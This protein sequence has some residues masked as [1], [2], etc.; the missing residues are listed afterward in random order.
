MNELTPFSEADWARIARDWTSWWNHDIARPMLVAF[1]SQPPDRVQP[2]W[3]AGGGLGQIPHSVPADAIAAE[4]WDEVRRSTWYG[5][6]WPRFWINYGPGVG[7]AFLGG[8]LDP[9]PNTVWFRPGIWQGRELGEIR[10]AFDPHNI[11]WRRIQDVTAA[12]L[13]HLARRAQVGFTDIGGNL[14]IAASLRDT[15]N[16]LIDCMDDPEG[17]DELCSRITPLWLRYY[18]EQV[19]L[20]APAGRG[21]SAWAPLWSPGRTYMLQS[22][23]AYMISPHQFARWVLPDIAACCAQLDHGFYHL[24]GK[25]QIPHLDHL[26]SVPGL[27]GVQWIPG[28]GQPESADPLWWPLLKRIRDA[29]K[30]VQIYSSGEAVL[31]MAREVPLTGFTIETWTSDREHQAGLVQAIQ[32]ANAPLTS[33]VTVPGAPMPI[34]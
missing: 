9:A 26:L 15:M 20:I 1:R 24:D 5:D 27:K 16:L 29:G 12:C 18:R 28:D 31:R 22:D 4:V 13:R 33:K 23:F 14:D 2:P 30:L 11:W 3:W 10:P 32:R 8:D 19:A 7:A 21:S 34:S 25:G 17:V 6:G